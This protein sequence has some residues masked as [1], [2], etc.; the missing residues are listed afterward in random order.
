MALYAI[1]W[2]KLSNHGHVSKT[3]CGTKIMYK[4]LTKL[5]NTEDKKRLLENFLSLS[6]LQIFTYILPVFHQQ[7]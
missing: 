6:G 4:I 5:T 3:Q 2:K 7:V 1:I